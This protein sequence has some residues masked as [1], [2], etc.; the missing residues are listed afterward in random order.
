MLTISLGKVHL[1]T[2]PLPHLDL[3]AL[4]RVLCI[5]AHPDDMEYG[6]SAAVAELTDAGIEVDYLLVSAGEAGIRD[7]EPEQTARI[8]REEQER[9][10][11]IVGVD[12]LEF[13]DFPDGLIENNLD[14]RRAIAAQIRRFRPDAV[15]TMTWEVSVQWGLNHADHRNVGLATV[16]AIRDADNP[17]LYP[18][19]RAQGLEPWATK[20]LWVTAGEV[21]TAIPVSP[22]SVERAVRSLQAH[23]LYLES[24]PDHM[25][26]EEFIPQIL[27][28]GGAA[29]GTEHA[30][31]FN[32]YEF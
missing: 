7:T 27:K 11:E 26:P 28:D 22:A 9:A 25:A 16:D 6:A 4:R 3:D 30:V 24:L 12:T 23:Q 19:L 8:R 31:V 15:I 20:Q 29:A 1:M 2:S 21:N 18:E 13:L 5:V 32:R 14:L 17:W 10:C